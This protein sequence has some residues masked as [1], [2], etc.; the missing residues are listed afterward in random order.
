MIMN[1]EEDANPEEVD[2]ELMCKLVAVYRE[3]LYN[4]KITKMENS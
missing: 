1:I 2:F 3:L 4:P